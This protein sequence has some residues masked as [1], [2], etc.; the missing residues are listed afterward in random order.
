MTEFANTKQS[1]FKLALLVVSVFWQQ[2]AHNELQTLSKLP[3][4]AE[5]NQ[6]KMQTHKQSYGDV[7]KNQTRK[8]TQG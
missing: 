2:R 4:E 5:V 8:Q 7:V 3:L 1:A 6:Q